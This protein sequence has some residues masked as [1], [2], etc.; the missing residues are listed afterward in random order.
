MPPKAFQ[1]AFFE[2][3]VQ[4]AGI[5]AIF[6]YIPEVYFFI[7]D[8]HS[9]MVSASPSILARLG[10]RGESDF[11]GKTDHDVFP[12][13]LADAFVVDDA[14]VFRTGKPLVNRLEL[15]INEQRRPDWCITSKMPLFGKQ[16]DV[17]GLMGVS[18]RDSGNGP[19]HAA[20][21]VARTVEF[22][23]GNVSRVLTAAEIARAAGLSERT[24]YRKVRQE[25]G[26]P[27]YELVLRLRIQMAAEA[28]LRPHDNLA[29]VA[30]AHGFCDQSSFTQHFRKRMGTTPKE[31]IS[32]HRQS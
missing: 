13:H 26:I 18:R 3:L 16:G 11:I 7:K 15:W 22:I 19:V 12:R 17:V 8:R 10:M 20:S 6:E 28:L 27:P 2:Q 9:R 23:R 1:L 14:L 24:L 25:F 29:A 30:L 4:P 5:R 31:F 21:E 32:R